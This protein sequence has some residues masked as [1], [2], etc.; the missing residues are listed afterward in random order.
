MSMMEYIRCQNVFRL[1][2]R[3]VKQLTGII[4]QTKPSR[5]TCLIIKSTWT[6][7]CDNFEVHWRKKKYH[8]LQKGLNR[9]KFMLIKFFKPPKFVKLLYTNEKR[10][11]KFEFV[12][13]NS[14]FQHL[15]KEGSQTLCLQTTFLWHTMEQF[16]WLVFS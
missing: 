5:A 6:N 1:N 11:I 16:S 10:I 4:V 12:L 3:N 8:N 9:W 15:L 2:V 7:M 14:N 13:L